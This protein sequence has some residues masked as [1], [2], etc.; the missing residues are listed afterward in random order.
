[1]SLLC[2]AL[3]CFHSSFAI[4]LKRNRKLVALLLLAYLCTV[5]INVLWLFITVPCFG[6]Q[7]MIVV[8]PNHTHANDLAQT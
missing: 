4:I 2:H 3:I 8:F 6:L 1:M 5:T 7:C